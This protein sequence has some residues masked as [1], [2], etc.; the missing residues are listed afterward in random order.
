MCSCGERRT[1][2]EAPVESS[3]SKLAV[4]VD[5]MSCG[6]CAATIKQAVESALPGTQVKADLASKLVTVYGANDVAAVRSIIIANGY[7]PTQ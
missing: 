1:T 4:Q 2:S 5:D 3:T 6:H 7:T